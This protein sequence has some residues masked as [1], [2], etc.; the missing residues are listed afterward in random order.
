MRPEYNTIMK[1]EKNEKSR[2]K[3]RSIQLYG[4]VY[5]QIG[6]LVRDCFKVYGVWGYQWTTEAEGICGLIPNV[7]SDYHREIMRG[8]VQIVKEKEPE[9]LIISTEKVM[10]AFTNDEEAKE[11]VLRTL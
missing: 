10:E 4:F 1:G 11:M 2:R 5:R 8:I 3:E 6:F 9:N 7:C